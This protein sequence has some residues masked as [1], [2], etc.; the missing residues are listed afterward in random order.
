MPEPT[1]TIQY[2]TLVNVEGPARRFG[3]V[4]FVPAQIKLNGIEFVADFKLKEIGR[5]HV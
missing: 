5:A 1:L 2:G 4:S 3:D